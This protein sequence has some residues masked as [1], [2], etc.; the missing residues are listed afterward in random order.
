MVKKFDTIIGLIGNP[1]VGKSTLFNTLTGARQHV[2]NWPGKTVERKEGIVFFKGKK[3]KIVDLPGSYSLTAF[4]PE[5]MIT[6]D[7]LLSE[8]PHMIVQIVDAQNLSRNL[9]VTLQL[10]E[11]HAPLIMAVNMI[12]SAEKKGITIRLTMLS[13]LLGIPVVGVDCRKKSDIDRLLEKI[14]QVKKIKQKPKLVYDTHIEHELKNINK[15]AKLNS[16]LLAIKL[17]E[18]DYRF[19]QEV[20]QKPY[21]LELKKQV[22]E[23]RVHLENIYNKDIDSILS[24]SRYGFI[25][26]LEKQVITRKKNGTNLNWEDACDALVMHKYVG[27]LF[28]VVLLWLIFQLSFR[29][30]TPLVEW[31]ENFFALLSEQTATVLSGHG[32]SPWLT[33][34]L[35]EAVIGGVGGI[36]SFIPIIAILFLL[37][38]ILEDSGYMARVAYVMDRFMHTL[39]LHGKAFIPLILGFGCNVPGIMATRT[40]EHKQERLLTILI[41]P[42]MSCGARLP[43]YALFATA[44]FPHHEG[45]VIFSLY[46]LGV[47]VAIVMGLMF[48]KLFAKKLSPEFVIELPPYRWPTLKGLF[49]SV[50]EKV[51]LFIKKAGSIILAFTIIIWFLANLPVGVEYAS[52]QSLIGM[53]GRATAPLFAPLGFG[54]WQPSVALIFGLVAKEVIVSTF[55]TLYS[56]TPLHTA[57]SHNFTHLSAMAFMVFTLL[58][59]PCVAVIAVIK[60]ETNSWK[61]P[62]FTVGYTMLIAYS[63]AF[64][65]YQGGRIIGF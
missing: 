9:F 39:G 24:N 37:L 6:S 30:S 18:R 8:K 19:E 55:G 7:F 25:K 23:S 47:V 46:A 59:T 17:M 41:N 44:F 65:V 52:E 33:S 14:E 63:M 35:T 40:L 56:P 32:I 15:I 29:I 4:T 27:I 5:E 34:L 50:W 20:S 61:W 53:L 38:A 58:Y 45:V 12:P 13:R 36:L 51:W 60:K 22:Q 3:I 43:V 10:I 2:G 28:F 1:N 26:G 21:Y 54:T 16:R 48:K 42:F 49:L 31:I 62:L 11:L 64:L 57:L